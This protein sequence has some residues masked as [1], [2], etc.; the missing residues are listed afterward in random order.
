MTPRTGFR[1]EHH[2]VVLL[3]A[4]T[5]DVIYQPGTPA[6][7]ARAGHLPAVPGGAGRARPAQ[8]AVL[9]NLDSGAGSLRAEIAA[10]RSKDTI[11]FAPSLKGQTIT[12]TSGELLIDK[13][14]T[15]AG[16]EALA[17]L[18]EA[19]RQ[20]W[21]QHLWNNVADTLARAQRKTTPEKKSDVK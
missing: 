7:R 13:D 11:V 9:N 20:A 19:E 1:K 3:L 2:H 10:A 12:L 5:R 6:S 8:H 15:I 14:L 21:Q 16:P 18:P 17:R 4:A